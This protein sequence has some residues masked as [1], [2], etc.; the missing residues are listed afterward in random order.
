MTTTTER[1][2]KHGRAAPGHSWIWLVMAVIV[3]SAISNSFA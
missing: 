2:R 3:L 1:R